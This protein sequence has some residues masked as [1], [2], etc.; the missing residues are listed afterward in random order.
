MYRI[1]KNNNQNGYVVI[2]R[3]DESF[4]VIESRFEGTDGI[5]DIIGNVYYI[6]PMG[7][8]DKETFYNKLNLSR[9]KTNIINNYVIANDSMTINSITPTKLIP[10]PDAH[11]K[12]HY[13]SF[14]SYQQML[15]T[16]SYLNYS[17]GPVNNGCGPTTGAMLVAFYDSVSIGTLYNGLLPQL[18]NGDKEKVDDLIIEM[19]DYMQTCNNISGNLSDPNNCTGTY[20]FNA[21]TGLT[22]YFDDNNNLHRYHYHQNNAAFLPL[23]FRVLRL[24]HTR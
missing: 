6:A 9:M 10:V 19:A 7:F 4:Q 22:N 24:S 11:Y 14:T 2:L 13:D 3:K 5:S 23:L 21:T 8:Y 12:T 1:I 15:D 16:P 17:Y 18:H 20:Y